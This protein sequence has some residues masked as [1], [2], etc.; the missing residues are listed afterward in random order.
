MEGEQSELAMNFLVIFGVRRLLE[1]IIHNNEEI[2]NRV[3]TKMTPFTRLYSFSTHVL[4]CL[5]LSRHD[6]L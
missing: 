5:Y 4:N 6:A 1:L 2:W 3:Y